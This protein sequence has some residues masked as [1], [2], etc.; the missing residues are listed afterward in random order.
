[1]ATRTWLNLDAGYYAGLMNAL[2]DADD[3]YRNN[4]L[5]LNVGLMF[6]L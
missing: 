1:V 5:R 6:G 4:N 3:T 2:K